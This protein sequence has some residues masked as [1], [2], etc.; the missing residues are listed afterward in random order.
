M[1]ANENLRSSRAYFYTFFWHFG[2]I[3]DQIFDQIFGQVFEQ[4]LN[5]FKAWCFNWHL[6]LINT[7]PRPQNFGQ[8]FD[9]IFGQ[10]FD[11]GFWI[12]K[13]SVQVYWGGEIQFYSSTGPENHE[14][15]KKF[16][17]LLFLAMTRR[18]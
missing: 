14:K 4:V 17:F 15:S 10:V 5:S 3:F 12:P 7:P 8:N 18:R 16:I 6:L 13:Y 11:Q 2:Q 1:K 9:Q